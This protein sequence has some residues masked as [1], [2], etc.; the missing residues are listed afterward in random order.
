MNG[1]RKLEFDRD[2]ALEAAM[3]VFWKKGFLGAS[4]QDL[5][6][7]MGINKPSL[8]ATFGNKEALFVEATNHYL[9]SYAK[10]NEVA[11][12][13]EGAPL[14]K[15]LK[16]YLATIIQGQCDDSTPKG[17]YISL[18]IAESAAETMPPKA[19]ECIDH[20]GGYAQNLLTTLFLEDAEAQ[21]LGLNKQAEQN[22]LFLVT[23]L[24]GTAAMARAG[25][26]FAEMEPVVNR[27]LKGLGM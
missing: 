5:T 18:C 15:R 8:Y 10:S 9:T 27:A 4:L 3:L 11:L 25:K 13:E 23:A 21:K 17:C 16:T 26:N 14:L 24:H 1:G 20:A 2:S 6:A 19:R 12:Y 22:A 7:A